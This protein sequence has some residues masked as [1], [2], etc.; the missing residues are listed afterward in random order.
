M[1]TSQ[2]S[3]SS[4]IRPCSSVH[5]QEF[6][7][8][9]TR[10]VRVDVSGVRRVAL[11]SIG[12][13]WEHFLMSYQRILDKEFTYVPACPVCSSRRSLACVKAPMMACSGAIFLRNALPG[14][15]AGCWLFSTTVTWE[16][17]LFCRDR[18]ID[19]TV[20][21]AAS[22]NNQKLKIRAE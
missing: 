17:W 20:R 10:L 14:R 13:T 4:C 18:D 11:P 22:W 9:H 21:T 7:D 12:S 3:G 6:P 1:L 8:L 16:S 15:L 5:R 19:M 2:K